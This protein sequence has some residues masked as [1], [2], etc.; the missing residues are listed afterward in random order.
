MPN[1]RRFGEG[2]EAVSVVHK[3]FRVEWTPNVWR[4]GGTWAVVDRGMGEVRLTVPVDDSRNTTAM[5]RGRREAAEL[6]AELNERE[7]D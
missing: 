3:R 2:R 4:P 6:A 1:V 7:E 5:E